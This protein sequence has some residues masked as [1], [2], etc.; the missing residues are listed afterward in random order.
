M[1]KLIYFIL[2]VAL[3]ILLFTGGMQGNPILGA[4]SLLGGLALTLAWGIWIKAGTGRI[5]FS[6]LLSIIPMIGPW[7][8]L[9]LLIRKTPQYTGKLTV[10]LNFSV[11]WRVLVALFGFIVA[12]RVIADYGFEEWW[13][14]L[15]GC[16]I[17]LNPAV[18]CLA[19]L[20]KAKW[21]NADVIIPVITTQ[22][23]FLLFPVGF[24]MKMDPVVTVLFC[25]GSTAVV[26]MSLGYL[27]KAK[28]ATR[29]TIPP[30]I[31]AVAGLILS[32]F[33]WFGNNERNLMLLFGIGGLVI[34]AVSVGY[35]FKAKWARFIVGIASI[36]LGISG[37]VGLIRTFLNDPT[38]FMNPG[39]GNYGFTINICM[40][41]LLPFGLMGWGV[42]TLIEV[43]HGEIMPRNNND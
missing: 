17:G 2:V 30:A 29:A 12:G 8:A 18:F 3:T 5:I 42:M 19:G 39:L 4:I 22:L 31:F 25:I 26:T 21:A 35:A 23:G 11:L 43:F 9:A 34:V 13:L 20:F 33:G 40:A 41:I 14:T 36:L 27:L 6:S 24:L 16:V 7:I 28:W 32:I 15:L 1:Y 38:E 10:L 37:A